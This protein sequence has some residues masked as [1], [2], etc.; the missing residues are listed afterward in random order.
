MTSKTKINQFRWLAATLMLV[1][2]MV[3]PSKAWAQTMYTVFDTETGTLTFK[4]DSS[5]PETSATQRVYEVGVQAKIPTWIEHHGGSITKVVFDESFK[6]ASPKTCYGWFYDCKQLTEIEHLD[7][8][9]TEN[10]TSMWYM[11]RNCSSLTSLDVSKFD[12]QKVIYM[13]QMF[14]KCSSLTSLDVSNFN[15]QNVS[16]MGSMFTGCSSLTSLDVS[17]FNTQNVT[18]MSQMF[19]ECSVVS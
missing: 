8:L 16:H 11:F 6:N 2:A 14:F 17:N 13:S 9:N 15:T 18:N 7:Y 1:A 12:T 4:Y 3:M 10:V 19:F 5:K